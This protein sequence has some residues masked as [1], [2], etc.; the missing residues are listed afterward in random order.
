MSNQGSG[1]PEV[2]ER[3][4]VNLIRKASNALH[5]AASRSG[6]S[7][8]DVIN[9]ALILYDA[10]DQLQEEGGQIFVREKDDS[11]VYRITLTAEVDLEVSPE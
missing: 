4:K 3:I 9:R 5:D 7:Q 10:L 1:A 8:T 6:L 11:T 2:V